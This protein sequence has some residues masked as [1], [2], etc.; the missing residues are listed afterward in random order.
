M[1]PVMANRRVRVTWSDLNGLA[2]GRYIPERLLDRHGHHAVTTLTMNIDREILPISGYSGDVGYPDMSTVPVVSSRRPGWEPETDVVVADLEFRHQPLEIAPRSALKRAVAAWQ[3]RGY[4][5]QLGYEMEFYVMAPNADAPGGFGLLPNRSHR[6]Y[7]VGNGAG[8]PALVFALYDAAERSELQLEGMM[9][10]FHPGQYE[11]NMRY[12]PAL[13]AADRA[14]LAKELTREVAA[15]NGFHVTYMGRP[16][17]ELVGSGLHINFSLCKTG[18]SG[19]CF[20]GPKDVH[21]LSAVA[22]RCLGGLLA[23]HAAISAFSAPLINSYKRLVPGLIAGYWANWG[24]DNRTSTYRVPG[25][26]G[27]A[28]RIENRMPCGSADPYLSAAAMLQAA[29]LGF[30]GDLDCGEPQSGDG[31]AEPNTDQ[32]TPTSL[33]EALDALADDA[34][35]TEAMGADLV[36]VYLALR[37][38]EVERWKQAGGDWNLDE[39]SDWELAQYLPFY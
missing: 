16:A 6:V 35:M 24:L 20:D 1:S 39:I 26:R 38:N 21:G 8:N 3:E 13:D 2:H 18:D 10:E 25:E 30:D 32:H 19:N 37:R 33:A 28:T 5:P 4:E 14:F 11:L 15:Q 29:L 7:G 27:G 36:R 12:G 34:E 31:D 22:R 9:G 23:H 17:A